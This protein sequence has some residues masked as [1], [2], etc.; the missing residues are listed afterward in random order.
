MCIRDRLYDESNA[1]VAHVC[2]DA[3]HGHKKGECTY[4]GMLKLAEE[5]YNRVTEKNP[6][7]ILAGECTPDRVSQYYPDVYKRQSVSVPT[8]GAL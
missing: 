7:Y 2:F 3:S 4:K 6:D 8:L 1:M 5:F